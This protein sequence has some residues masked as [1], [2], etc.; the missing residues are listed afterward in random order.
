MKDSNSAK[1]LKNKANND[2]DWMDTG[3]DTWGWDSFYK[4]DFSDSDEQEEHNETNRNNKQKN[5]KNE[6][7][8]ESRNQIR[9]GWVED[10]HKE[11]T[12]ICPKIRKEVSKKS[13][14]FVLIDPETMTHSMLDILH[15]YDKY[16]SIPAIVNKI[17]PFSKIESLL[18]AHQICKNKFYS[19]E[20]YFRL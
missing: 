19:L 1:D 9:V 8:N 5:N 2:E 17:F 18:Q 12:I 13:P 20:A 14:S 10:R 4:Y 6:N 15:G 3:D 16:G 7:K 11:I